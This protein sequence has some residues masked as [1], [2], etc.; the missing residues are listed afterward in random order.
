MNDRYGVDPCAATSVTELAIL[1]RQD[2]EAHPAA[3]LHEAALNLFLAGAGAG[4]TMV[5]VGQ[6]PPIP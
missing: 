5:M 3:P 4:E 2:S 6:S 1:L